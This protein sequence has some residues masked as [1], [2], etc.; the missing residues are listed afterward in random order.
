MRLV[1]LRAEIDADKCTGCRTCEKVCPTVAVRVQ[2]KKAVVDLKHCTGCGGCEQRCPAYAITMQL[3]ETPVRLHVPPEKFD[4]RK[5]SA[6]CRKARFNPEQI[7][8]Y[9][10]ETRAEEVAAAILSGADTPEKISR[11]IGIRTGCKVECIQPVL[12][13]L[14]AAG[15]TPPRPEGWQ[16]YGLTPTAWEIPKEVKEKYS[17]RGFYFD[18]DIKLFDLIA[19]AKTKEQEGRHA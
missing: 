13:L 17:R 16:W 4:R 15:I 11:A 18:D 5:I 9:C 1:T 2:K 14:A 12:R 7:V 10:T 6:L 3:R 8:C 19:G